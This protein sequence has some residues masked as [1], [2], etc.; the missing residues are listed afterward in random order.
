MNYVGAARH[1]RA[2]RVHLEFDY[3]IGDPRLARITV[4]IRRRARSAS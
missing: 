3:W 4:C 1:G 2:V